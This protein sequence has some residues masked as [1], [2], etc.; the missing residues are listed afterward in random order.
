MENTS[1]NAL[2]GFLSLAVLIG[3]G[4]YFYQRNN[5]ELELIKAG[6]CE[7]QEEAL[8]YPPPTYVCI[9]RNSDGICILRAPVFHEPYMRSHWRC[10]TDNGPEWFWRRKVYD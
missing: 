4:V 5:Y 1:T 6:R 3:M 9:S 2:I 8:Y 10:T 7:V